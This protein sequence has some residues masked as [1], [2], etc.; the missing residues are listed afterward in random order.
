[1]LDALVQ[2]KAIVSD[3]LTIPVSYVV[4]EVTYIHTYTYIYVYTH[5]YT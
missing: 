1:V 2:Y 4:P 5:I 3:E